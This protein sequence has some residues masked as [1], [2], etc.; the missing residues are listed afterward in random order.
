MNIDFQEILKELEFR[1][2]KGI[3][4]LNEEQQVTTLV[5]ILRENGVPDANEFAQRARVIFG[6]V[7]EANKKKA[8][9][10]KIGT[11]FPAFSKDGEKLVYF[12]T[13]ASLDTALKQ[14][15]HITPKQKEDND[16]KK[17][18][19]KTD[20]KQEPKQLGGIELVGGAE[21]RKSRKQQKPTSFDDRIDSKVS[22]NLQ[23]TYNTDPQ[24]SQAG[25]EYPTHKD[26][27]KLLESKKVPKIKNVNV[28][29]DDV[30]KALGI[31]KGECKFPSKYVSVMALALTHAKG[32]YTITD[33]TDAAGAGTLDSTLGEL[34]VLIGSTIE[35]EKSRANF[36]NY[37]R[38]NVAKGGNQSPITRDW[39]DAAEES[40]KAFNKKL[41]RKCGGGYSVQGNFWDIEKE[42][43]G[44]G[45]KNYK[46]DKGKS[47]DINTLVN[48]TSKDG[49]TTQ[50]WQQPSLKKSK[51]VNAMNATTSRVFSVTLNRY[52]S[53]AEKK[54]YED[55]GDE[56]DTY[57]G[58]DKK[59]IVKVKSADG[60]VKDMTVENRVRELNA[61]MKNLERK[62]ADKIP[63]SANPEYA[64][65]IQKQLHD[66]LLNDVDANKELNKFFTNWQSMKNNEKMELAQKISKKYLSQKGDA[67]GEQ[68]KNMFDRMSEYEMNTPEKFNEVLDYMELPP[69]EKSK[70]MVASMNAV[71]LTNEGKETVCGDYKKKL[72]KNSHGHS[73]A[74]LKYLIEDDENKNALL[75]N[76]SKT[77]PLK[78]LMEGKEWAILGE[79]GGGINLDTDTITKCLGTAKYEDVV[80]K[81]QIVPYG[82]KKE[83][84][85]VYSADNGKRNIP[86]SKINCRPDGIMYGTGWK[87]EMDIHDGFAAC[88]K[89]HDV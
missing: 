48:C 43:A 58:L 55:S 32:K 1:V 39:I 5:E 35:D 25:D 44:A 87:L 80:E 52:G 57:K 22:Q 14:G 37:L 21:K 18:V 68:L 54:L 15:S 67:Y 11:K 63:K 29:E 75:E 41:G 51:D 9:T 30:Y 28:T 26:R 4:N 2:P 62:Y 69:K 45:I 31:K 73:E 6:Y 10:K 46:R 7:S 38:D 13:K 74:V 8:S 20:K 81:L 85:L 42:A 89:S 36:Y 61:T 16:K 79:K 60:S 33:L 71:S 50:I 78:E 84:T 49:K 76:I 47:T 23:K 88:C 86:I 66:K 56:I 70:L 65:K 40:C 72:L 12:K 82:D 3:I 83:P 34:M 24:F 77:F 19:S 27:L 17:S 53:K 64:A 59:M